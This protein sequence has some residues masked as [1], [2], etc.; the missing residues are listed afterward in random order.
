MG[1]AFTNFFMFFTTL[2]SAANKLA[3]AVDNLATIA[4]KSSSQFAD[5]TAYSLDQKMVEMKKEAGIA[6]LPR[7]NPPKAKISAASVVAKA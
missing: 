6:D 1:A 7:A 3:S 2:F 5:I 4:E